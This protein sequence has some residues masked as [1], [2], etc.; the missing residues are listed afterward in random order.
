MEFVD[1]DNK[2][3]AFLRLRIP[4]DNNERPE[5]IGK[6]LIREIKTFGKEARIDEEGEYQ[7][8]GYGRKLL[9]EAENITSEMGLHGI[10]VISGIGVREYFRKNGYERL[11][12]YMS[13]RTK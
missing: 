8:R 6:S 9:Q 13:K 3:V 2:I 7:H 1:E 4:G 11:G 5:L 12:P 10:A